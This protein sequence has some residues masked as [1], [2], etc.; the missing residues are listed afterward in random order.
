M[1]NLEDEVE[2]IRKQQKVYDKADEIRRH[3]NPDAA[4]IAALYE[5]FSLENIDTGLENRR[6]I[7]AGIDPNKPAKEIR[8]RKK[9]LGLF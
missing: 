6:K 5:K 7:R 8:K 3:D 9:F 1:T 4:S 2:A